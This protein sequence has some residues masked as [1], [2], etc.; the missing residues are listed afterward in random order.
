[1][2]E[3]LKITLFQ[4]PRVRPLLITLGLVNTGPPPPWSY[5]RPQRIGLLLLM[6]II[7]A[8]YGIST[9][10]RSQE[11][12][13]AYANGDLVAAAA[14]LREAAPAQK[15]S[16]PVEAEAFP[17]DPNTVTSADLQRLGL[18]EKQ[19]ASFI[20]FRSARPFRNPAEIDKLYVLGPDQK[21]RLIR[22][23][24]MPDPTD[25]RAAVAPSTTPTAPPETFTFDPNTISADSFQLLGFS[26]REAATLIK[27][28]SYRP[29]TFRKPE[30]LLRVTA[31]DSLR[32]GALL[33]KIDIAL[34][35]DPT[36]PASPPPPP[37]KDVT[38]ID[39]NNATVADFET[40]PGVGPYRA[41]KIVEYRERLGGYVSA[42]QL[43][44][45][46]GLPDSVFQKMKPYLLTSP[47][48]RALYVNQ[49]NAAELG[50]HPYLNRRTAEIIV[51]Y[52]ENHGPFTSVEDLKNVRAITAESLDGLLP[53][54]NFAQ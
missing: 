37:P 29:Q 41:E 50:Q 47:V 7:M 23:A 24:V 45:A 35:P 54:L 26:E 40:L 14:D 17:F 25:I 15:K 38:P 8:A 1:M 48:R 19:A 27:Y 22:L 9:W 16:T 18:T 10:L 28:R 6:V 34:A 46:Y 32:V 36:A 11:G 43:S 13:P 44:F 31:I 2:F 42:R 51:R 30:D 33:G 4:P 21:E 52:R 5:T 3:K 53:Y 39:I 20:K 49:M 12:Q